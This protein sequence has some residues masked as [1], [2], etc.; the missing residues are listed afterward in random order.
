M[1]SSFH[2][3]KRS[4]I[5]EA[6]TYRL[7]HT[8]V[9]EMHALNTQHTHLHPPAVTFEGQWPAGRAGFERLDEVEDWLVGGVR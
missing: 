2:L 1:Q 8:S 3:L 6:M 7:K 4:Q 5:T 9:L